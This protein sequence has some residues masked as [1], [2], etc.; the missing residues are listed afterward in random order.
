MNHNHSLP[1]CQSLSTLP[2]SQFTIECEH[3]TQACARLIPGVTAVLF[4]HVCG[5]LDPDPVAGDMLA[6]PCLLIREAL[7]NGGNGWM[8]YDHVFHKQRCINP[9][10]PWNMP[11]PGLQATTILGQWTS[12]MFC[13]ICQEC[14]YTAS[15]CT[16]TPCSSSSSQCRPQ[17]PIHPRSIGLLG[18]QRHCCISVWR[19]TKES[20]LRQLAHIIT[21][22]RHAK[23]HT[24]PDT[25]QILQSILSINWLPPR[26]HLVS[27][28]AYLP[29]DDN[30]Q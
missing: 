22:M 8:E 24:G 7:Q 10:L 12:R 16:L 6:Y 20:A 28:I 30:A 26:F 21:F 5:G 9:C 25:V 23:H 18:A 29:P 27:P 15:H 19:G 4:Q 3:H 17:P 2:L 1:Q 13:T 14:D 11:D